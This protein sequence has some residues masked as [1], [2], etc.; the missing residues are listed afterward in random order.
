MNDLVILILTATTRMCNHDIGVPI[1]DCLIGSGNEVTVE[2][3]L[4]GLMIEQLSF[5]TED[6]ADFREMLISPLGAVCEAHNADF[7]S[8]TREEGE[9][10][11]TKERLVIRMCQQ[12]Q[13]SKARLAKVALEWTDHDSVISAISRLSRENG[14]PQ[15]SMS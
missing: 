5:D 7:C 3:H 15:I 10:T 8:S 14:L 12:R 4:T 6:L 2:L 11:A 1:A 9:C 13:D